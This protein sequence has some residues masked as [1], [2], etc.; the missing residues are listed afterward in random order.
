MCGFTRQ[1]LIGVITTIESREQKRMWNANN[2]IPPENP[3]AS[4]T[5]DVECFFSTMRDALGK[6][7]TLKQVKPE[8]RKICK[9]FAKRQD[10]QLPYFYFTSAHGRFCEGKRPDFNE[11]KEGKRNPRKIRP[12]RRELIGNLAPSRVFTVATISKR[13]QFHNIPV[14]L[15]PPPGTPSIHSFEHSY[16]HK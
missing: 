14:N 7:F 15:P 11:G 16:C 4:T 2:I 3:R 10:S 13:T 12:R 5:D 8:M 9:E 6:N 1:V